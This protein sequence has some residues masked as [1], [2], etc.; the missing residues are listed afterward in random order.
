MLASIEIC[1]SAIAIALACTMPTLGAPVFK[2]IEIA[3]SRLA[4]RRRL[5]VVTV[6]FAALAARLAVLPVL[7]VPEPAIHDEFS[8]LLI[9]DTFAQGRLSNP[10]HPMW[11]HFETFHVNQKPTYASMYYPGQ[12]VLLAVGKVIFGHLFWGVWLSVGLMCAAICWALQGWMPASWALLGGFLAV[13]RLAAFSYW[14]NTYY[15]GALAALG[16]ALVL[17]AL[18]RIKKRQRVGDA[19]LMGLGIAILVNTR[20]YESLFFCFPIAAA[21]L[22]WIFGR[23]A[24]KLPILIRRTIVP[25]TV[26]LTLALAAMGYYFWRVTG[27]PFRIPY[28]VNM[29]TYHLVYFPWQMLA[30]DAEYHHTVMREFY[31]GPP[32]V[33]QYRHARLHPLLWLLVKPLPHLIFFLGPVLLMP[34]VIWLAVRPCGTLAKSLSRKTRFMLLLCGLTMI[35]MM[36]PVYIPPA[37]YAAPMTAAIYALLLQTMRYVRLW[38]SDGQPSGLFLVRAVPVICLALLPVRA[39]ASLLHIPVPVT[40]IHTWYTEDA[41][42]LERARILDQLDREAGRHLVIV[43]YSQDHEILGEWVYNRADIDNAKVVW[44]RDMGTEK[45]EELLKFFKDRH[46]WLL[47]PDNKPPKLIAYKCT[48]SPCPNM[49]A[50]GEE[51]RPKARN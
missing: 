17:G 36:L 8:H 12:G 41:H 1:L 3:F 34:F 24:P 30:P 31:Q 27:S 4:R 19:L 26:V 16:G 13:M 10:T 11:V 5:A 20:P 35:G 6:G 45:N 48:S 22:A 2:C 15:G 49:V 51:Q 43:R 18:P 14:A 42:N 44:A 28:Q 9:A 39:V 47:E 23:R 7:P 37:H 21:L 38:R 46:V 29:A 33:G 50:S 32:V 40:V 25:M